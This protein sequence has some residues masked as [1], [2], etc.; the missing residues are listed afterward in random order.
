LEKK[1]R[2]LAAMEV[3]TRSPAHDRLRS[4]TR[5]L[6]KLVDSRFDL[7]T[8]SSAAAYSAFLLANWPF[9]SIETSLESAGIHHV[10]PDWDK[11]R[12]REALADDLRQFGIPPPSIR[13][14]A[15]DPDLGTLLGWSY[16][17]EGSRLGAAMILRTIERSGKQV[18]LG[19]H[20][21]RHGDGEH[22]WQGYKDALSEIDEDPPAISNACAGAKLA[23]HYFLATRVVENEIPSF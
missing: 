11:R 6:H 20:F 14:L 5:H 23:F 13:P 7:N 18:A 8:I 4:S 10:L 3:S 12:R 17:L 21:L 15:I 2:S 1:L 19:T 16:V 9:A 22:L